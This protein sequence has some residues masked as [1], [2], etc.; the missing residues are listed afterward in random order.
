MRIR[1]IQLPSES[2]IEPDELTR[3]EPG[4]EYDV[5]TTTACV[6]LAEGW[7]E[8]VSL[9]EPAPIVPFSETDPFAP[10][11]YRDADAPQNLIREHYP[12]YLDESRQIAADFERRRR[13]RAP[14]RK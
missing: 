1:I 13:P 8:P 2:C 11:P 5:G 3:F 7:A 4:G 9:E 6:A 10:Q 14:R 12:P